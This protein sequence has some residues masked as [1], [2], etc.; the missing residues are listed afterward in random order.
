MLLIFFLNLSF[1]YR[2]IFAVATE[3]SVFLY[4]TQ[5][6]M[7]FAFATGIHYSNLSDLSWSHDGRLLIVT[8]IDGFCTFLIFKENELG[9]VYNEP[10]AINDTTHI[11]EPV[12]DDTE[13]KIVDTNQEKE[14]N[15]KSIKSM[16][17]NKCSANTNLKTKRKSFGR[18][19]KEEPSTEPLVILSDAS[20]DSE[21][22]NE[23]QSQVTT[24][25]NTST[26][27]SLLDSSLTTTADTSKSV[28][29]SNPI[30]I[31]NIKSNAKRIKLTPI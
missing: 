20:L 30:T 26:A 1:P 25:I 15:K 27:T 31:I 22:K 4:D 7:P 9:V 13:E 14:N 29:T 19:K 17:N 23:M 18:N 16:F 3:D 24:V 10:L 2:Y 5:I 11:S 28:I 8:S 21:H 12:N 6:L